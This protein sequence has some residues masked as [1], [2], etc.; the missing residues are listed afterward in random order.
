MNN[1]PWS[2]KKALTLNFVILATLPILFVGTFALRYLTDSMEKEISD[3]NLLLANAYA[4]ELDRFLDESTQRLGHLASLLEDGQYIFPE[5]LNSYLES[6]VTIKGGLEMVRVLDQEGIVTNLAPFDQNILGLD[7]SR[8]EY[9]VTA[10]ERQS[11]YWS[12]VFISPQTGASTLVLAIPFKQGMVVGHLSLSAVYEI[13]NSLNMGHSGYVAVLD[14]DG[15]VI[16]HQQEFLVAQRSNLSNLD[17]IANGLAGHEGTF[18]YDLDKQSHIGS[19]ALVTRTQWVVAI[20]Q[21]IDEVFLPIRNLKLIIYTGMSIA[22]LLAVMTALYS[23]Q[24]MLSPLRKLEKNA[25]QIANGNYKIDP[26]PA[27]YSEVIELDQSFKSM[28]QKIEDRETA[29]RT[30]EERFRSTFEQV[31]VGFAHVS[32][33]GNFMRINRKFCDIVGYSHDEMIDLTFQQITHPDDLNAD[34]QQVQKLLDGEANSYSMEKRYIHKEGNI[35]W[36]NLTVTLLSDDTGKIN[37]FVAVVE[38][39]TDKKKLQDERDRILTLSPDLICIA[40]MD[41][42]F[43]YVNPAWENALGYSQEELLTKPFLDFIQPDDHLKS[44]AE[45]EKLNTG[46]DSID[47]ENR[48][49]HIDGSFR[50]ILWVV[51]PLLE[52]SVLYCIGRDITESKV[53]EE[54]LRVSQEKFYKVFQSSPSAISITNLESGEFVDVNQSFERIFG[55]SREEIIGKSIL[56]INIWKNSGDRPRLMDSYLKERHLEITNLELLRKSGET[57]IADANFVVMDLSGEDYSI[58][59]ISDITDRKR[60]E[61]KIQQYQAR[62]KALSSQLTIAE[63]QERGRIAADLHDHIGQT[64]AFIRIQLARAKKHRPDETLQG[65]LDE[66]SQSLLETV[67]ATKDM[68]FDLSS[69]LLHEIG[70]GA[71]ISNWLEEQVRKKHGISTEFVDGFQHRVINNDLRTILF[72]NVRELVANVIRHSQ[73]SHV[74]VSLDSDGNEVRIIVHDKGVGFDAEEEISSLTSNSGFGLFSIRERMEDFGGTLTIE[75]E[76]GKGCKATLTAP[77]K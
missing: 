32:P 59:V 10:K 45:V 64:L 74:I 73:A 27:A 47:F 37:Y 71:A 66:I 21:P 28:I 46:H 9:F 52:E 3:K 19:I 5:K 43:K 69:P 62:L 17:H 26:V 35:V 1:M 25:Q 63:E 20:S 68:V 51:T 30:S 55:Y 53:A 7:M 18:R 8:Q 34:L 11:S 38:D 58:A 48:F 60:A 72:R 40:G 29:L 2:F 24:R 39:I 16:A 42:F 31:A 75:S 15:T 54:K 49:I 76:A 61:E 70:L 67:Q 4:S 65:M 56:D 50:N 22:I 57:V 6:L 23:L 44:D 33:N 12:N 13:I 14:R 41:G 77:L 36:V